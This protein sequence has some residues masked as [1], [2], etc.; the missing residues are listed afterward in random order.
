MSITIFVIVFVFYKLFSIKR[1]PMVSFIKDQQLV[2]MFFGLILL[3][4]LK[5]LSTSFINN[6]V[7]PILDP[8]LPFLS[9]KFKLNVGPFNIDF[10]N[11]AS[12][13][14]IFGFNIYFVYF[15]YSTTI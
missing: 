13:L 7:V 4:N 1:I 14:L 9:C 11:F 8:I 5:N 10:G 12:D 15:I 3:S 6:I 2:K